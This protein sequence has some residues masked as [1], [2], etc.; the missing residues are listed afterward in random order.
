MGRFKNVKVYLIS[1]L[2]RV[3]RRESLKNY[4]CRNLKV[5]F[6][7]ARLVALNLHGL[8]KR[9][10]FAKRLMARKAFCS[11]IYGDYSR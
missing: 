9:L 8:T 7:V 2:S 6:L 11:A 3:R 4:L 5:N 10:P 1:P